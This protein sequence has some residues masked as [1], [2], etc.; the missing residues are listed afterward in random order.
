MEN[1]FIIASRAKLRFETSRGLAS[2][3]DL[4]DLPLTARGNTP[5][6]DD[7]A[8]ELHREIK[9]AEGEISFVTQAAPRTTELQTMFDIVKFVIDTK[10][11]E[12]AVEKAAEEKRATK[13]K[14][15]GLISAKKDEELAS[16]SPEELEA[17]LASL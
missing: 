12:R 11:A 15:L 9:D 13:Q 1:Q 6:L 16:K 3:E 2:A 7:I 5:N 17:M 10:L 14:I 4:W 8:K